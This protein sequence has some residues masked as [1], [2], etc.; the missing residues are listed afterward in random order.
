MGVFFFF[1]SSGARKLSAREK[2]GSRQDSFPLGGRIGALT[3]QITSSPFVGWRGPVWQPH[4]PNW[5]N[6]FF[7]DF[8]YLRWGTGAKQ[9]EGKKQTPY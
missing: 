1:F 3:M 9:R 4:W 7:R 2:G 5:R 8:V 6:I